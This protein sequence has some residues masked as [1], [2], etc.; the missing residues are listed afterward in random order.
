MS[1]VRHSG[2]IYLVMLIIS[3]CTSCCTQQHQIKLVKSITLLL[4]FLQATQNY[5]IHPIFGLPV[6]KETRQVE[7]ARNKNS[8]YD[9]RLDNQ[10]S[11]LDLELK[12]RRVRLLSDE[13]S[14]KDFLG[15]ILCTQGCGVISQPSDSNTHR[16]RNKEVHK[17]KQKSGS[18][19]KFD[20]RLREIR[21]ARQT[22]RYKTSSFEPFPDVNLTEYGIKRNL[23]RSRSEHNLLKHCEKYNPAYKITK[24]QQ[25]VF[26]LYQ[27][28]TIAMDAYQRSLSL[29]EP[30][31]SRSN[32]SKVLSKNQILANDWFDVQKPQMMKASTKHPPGKKSSLPSSRLHN[33]KII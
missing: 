12:S 19:N 24:E 7:A 15:G 22:E 13:A 25:T 5:E 10:I 29:T 4:C 33:S 2:V 16:A 18:L 1:Q 8:S 31:L 28:K 21:E 14:V 30:P 23:Y 27:R 32:K 6:A 17:R 3:A 11:S 26:P 9:K 20:E